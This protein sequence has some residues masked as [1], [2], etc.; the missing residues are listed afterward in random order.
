MLVKRK[1]CKTTDEKN[2]FLLKYLF[3]KESKGVIVYVFVFNSIALIKNK[4]VARTYF[5]RG[6]YCETT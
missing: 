6:M 4:K 3:Q 2:L 5:L 1:T